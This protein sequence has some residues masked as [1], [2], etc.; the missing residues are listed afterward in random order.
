MDFT[1]YTYKK[2]LNALQ[3]AGY[4]FQT[5]TEFIREPKEKSV[6]LRHDVDK[7][8]RNSEEFAKIQKSLGIKG[9]YYFRCVPES[10]DEQIIRN[11]SQMN[12]EVGYHYEEMDLCHGNLD[13]ALKLFENCLTKAFVAP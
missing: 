11:I 2:L 6:M 4:S 7:R 5:F 1:I 8:P 3:N 12:H 9:T 10:Y 13:S